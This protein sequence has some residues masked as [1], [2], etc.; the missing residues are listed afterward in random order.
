MRGEGGLGHFRHS[1]QIAS[2]E[3]QARLKTQSSKG[4]N[5]RKIK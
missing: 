4:V 1:G 5:I 2:L 3:E